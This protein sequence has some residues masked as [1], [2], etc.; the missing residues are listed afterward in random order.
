MTERTAAIMLEARVAGY[1][2]APAASAHL[3]ID[4]ALSCAPPDLAG[5]PLD[6]LD[7]GIVGPLGRAA[8]PLPVLG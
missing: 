8:A 5:D 7:E 3:D 6:L 1:A 4:Q 2:T